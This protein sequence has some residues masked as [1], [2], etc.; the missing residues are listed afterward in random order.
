MSEQQSETTITVSG[1]GRKL[2]VLSEYVMRQAVRI[3]RVRPARAG[4]RHTRGT[5]GTS[6]AALKQG[7]AAYECRLCSLI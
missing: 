3:Q 7:N 1:Y 5:L 4:C 6:K 2:F